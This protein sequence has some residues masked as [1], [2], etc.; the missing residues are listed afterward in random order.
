MMEEAASPAMDEG[1]RLSV[2]RMLVPLALA[3]FICSYAGSNMNV[4]ITSIGADLNTTVRGV[5]TAITL[6]LLTMAVLMIPGSKL[7]DRWGRKR[8]FVAGLTLYGTGA[9]VSAIAP[10]LAILIVGYSALEGV[11]SALLI[12]PVY[13]LTTVLVTDPTARARAFGLISGM[14]G[15]GA[16]A[17][18]LIGG[19]ITTTISWRASFL[20]QAAVIGVIVLLSRRIVDPLPADPSRRFDVVGAVL[21]GLGLFF[22]VTGILLM[23]SS[24]MWTIVFAIIG[25][26]FLAWF[27]AHVRRDARAGREPLLS[28]GLFRNR[29]SNLALVTQNIQWL[30]LMGLAFVVSVYLQVELGYSAIATGLV[31]TAATA[32]ILATSLAAERFA[33]RRSQATL[34]RA[35]FLVA[36]VGIGLLL[37][38][39]EP[40]SGGWA[41]VPGL[42]TIGVGIGAML[43]PSVN[44][45]QSSFPEALQGEI[46]GV[47]RS[48]SN[49]GS[50]L[51][52]AIGGTILASDLASGTRTYGL[53]LMVLAAI[54]LVGLIVAVRLPSGLRQT[55]PRDAVTG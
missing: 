22:F 9:V 54:G 12:P 20:L 17:G 26:G 13:I 15:I 42:L 48:V 35:G 10:N 53:A 18:P 50:S 30:L 25:F 1:A 47:S 41:F 16:A 14:A 19:L 21:S 28:V 24:W 32:G 7:T 39:V 4:A 3:Q 51:G 29:T 49:L 40:T 11:G 23:D 5:Q 37:V 44:V 38:L 8:C 52:T 36:L 46:S 31:F 33:T 45:V 2:R 55:R 27:V 43:T 6:F 34:I